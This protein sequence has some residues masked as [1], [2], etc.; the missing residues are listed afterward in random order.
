MS[1]P[2]AAAVLSSSI[3]SG[4]SLLYATLG[5]LV[6][7]RAG[8]VNLGL[9]GLMLIGAAV[10]FAATSLAGDPYIGVAAAGLVCLAA[11][12]IFGFIVIERRANQLAAGLTL[13]YPGI[14]GHHKDT[15][16]RPKTNP[17]VTSGLV[18]VSRR[19]RPHLIHRSVKLS[20][21]V[22]RRQARDD[23][24]ARS[25]K[26]IVNAVPIT[27]RQPRKRWPEA[28]LQEIPAS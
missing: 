27:I 18:G 24:Q 12:L 8:I 23:S 26:D 19:F 7:E 25:R 17:K 4:T 14:T 11:N 28:V 15:F 9:E 3:L 10:G 22:R 6:G 5:E 2:F 16:N 1:T 20:A 13:I 21:T